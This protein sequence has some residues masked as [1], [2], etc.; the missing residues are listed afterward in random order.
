MAKSLPVTPQISKLR[1]NKREGQTTK[2]SMDRE[3]DR[4][5]SHFLW[6]CTLKKVKDHGSLDRLWSLTRTVKFPIKGT[7]DH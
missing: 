6:L 7:H 1:L 3:G 4:D 2:E 5:L